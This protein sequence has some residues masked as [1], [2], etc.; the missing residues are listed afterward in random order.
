MTG[1]VSRRQS[2]VFW[3]VII[4]TSTALMALLV[5]GG[6]FMLAREF[7]NP[8]VEAE[9]EVVRLIEKEDW[10]GLEAYAADCRTEP[11]R[12][13]DGTWRIRVFYGSLGDLG[14]TRNR[15]EMQGLLNKIERWEQ[16]KPDSITAKTMRARMHEAIGWMV[17]GGGYANTVSERDWDIFHHHTDTAWDIA[18]ALT[19]EPSVEAAAYDLLLDLGIARNVPMEKMEELLAAG[20]A[21]EPEYE[22][23]YE[24]FLWNLLP[25]WHGEHGDA[26]KFAVR[27]LEEEGEELY[28]HLAVYLWEQ[29]PNVVQYMYYAD[30]LLSGLE[31]LVDQY[32][33]RMDCRDTLLSCLRFYGKR[34]EE[35]ALLK[36]FD[37]DYIAER[38]EDGEWHDWLFEDAPFPGLKPLHLAVLHND[39][40][41]LA[42]LLRD[43]AD[44]DER[45]HGNTPLTQA[46]EGFRDEMVAK[47]LE[48]GAAPE[49]TDDASRGPL[50]IAADYGQTDAVWNLVQ[51][52]A[53]VNAATEDGWTPLHYAARAGDAEMLKTLLEKDAL[54]PNTLAGDYTTPLLLSIDREKEDACLALLADPRVRVD[55]VT[56]NSKSTPLHYAVKTG[57]ASI[58]RGLLAREEVNVNARDSVGRTPLHAA[59]Q[60]GEADAVRI[61]LEDGR[62]QANTKNDK[63]NTP[64]IAAAMKGNLRIVEELFVAPDIGLN[65]TGGA[66]GRTALHHAAHKGYADV[67]AALLEHEDIDAATQNKNGKTALD[68]AR[69]AGHEEVVRILQGKQ[70]GL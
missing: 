52:G 8:S 47:L 69:A 53:D 10:D 29:E 56:A 60:A 67:V 54:R 42:A 30:P 40:D 50:L 38:W 28:A 31:K 36:R 32:P 26:H 51:A 19:Q 17:H 66:N 34:E 5:G 4:F 11:L 23:L 46:V 43:G 21:I 59:A 55:T 12:D 6:L 70:D 9:N 41:A 33:E 18:E 64:L 14:D 68:L 49:K 15:I 45:S 7:A 37:G 25:R 62:I 27:V 20:R 22:A 48:L 16:A 61:L 44:I 57:S 58:L 3:I 35:L 39:P 24:A 13:P 65:L 2:P 1:N 63:G